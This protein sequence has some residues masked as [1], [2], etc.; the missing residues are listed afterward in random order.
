MS[1]ESKKEEFPTTETMGILVRMGGGG[2]GGLG[3]GVWDGLERRMEIA[4]MNKRIGIF[5][6]RHHLYLKT[7]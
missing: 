2:G 4:P 3:G 7:R 5:S 6:H 1:R